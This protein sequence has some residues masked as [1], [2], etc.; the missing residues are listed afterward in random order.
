MLPAMNTRLDR[1]AGAALIAL[2]VALTACARDADPAGDAPA[3]ADTAV[4][5]PGPDAARPDPAGTPPLTSDGWDR[6]RIGMTR[7]EI[8]AIAGADANPERVRGA[9]PHVCDQYRPV[10]APDGMLLML[11]NDTLSRISVA[12]DADVRTAEGIGVGDSASAVLAA[13][14]ARAAS[15]PHKYREAPSAYVT[16]WSVP[17]DGPRPARGLVFDIGDDGLVSLIHAGGPSIR[18]VEGCL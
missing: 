11:E 8:T 16:V 2:A 12:R 4:A 17:P 1:T 3:G 6:F 15:T 13:Y 18:Y 10:G 7:A 5:A 9:E 14:G